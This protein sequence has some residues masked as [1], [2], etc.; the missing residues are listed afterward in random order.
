MIRA[1]IVEDEPQ[2]ARYLAEIIAEVDSEIRIL[3]AYHDLTP[4][5]EAIIML[6]PQMIFLD[7]M[8]PEGSS[9]DLLDAIRDQNTEVIFVTAFDIFWQD[10]FNHAAAGYIVKPVNREKLVM[11]I[12]NAKKRIKSGM[13]TNIDELLNNLTKR[14]SEKTEKIAL[15][16]ADGY[17]FVSLES[18]VHLESSN[19]YTVIVTEDKRKIVS[20]YNLGEF[21]KILPKEHFIHVHKSHIISLRHIVKFDIKDMSVEMTDK[22]RIP[23]SRRNRNDFMEHFFMPKRGL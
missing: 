14:Q 6:K 2:L 3:G 1:L 18:I 22:S 15:P 20:S 21:R 4:A 9:F 17:Q 11:P 12:A 23:V 13:L 8:L 19:T 5:R 7:I 16:T 10:A